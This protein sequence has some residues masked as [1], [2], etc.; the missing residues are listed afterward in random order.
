MRVFRFFAW[1]IMPAALLASC[2]GRGDEPAIL[3]LR[4]AG[5][6]GAAQLFLLQGDGP[7]RQLTGLSDSDADPAAP[8]VIDYAPSPDGERIVYAVQ[9]GDD[10][11]LR[12]VNLDGGQDALLLACPGV[13]CD[14]PVWAPDGQRLLFERWGRA[15]TPGPP[16]LTWLDPATGATAPLIEGDDTP[17]SGARFSPGGEWLSYV[18][19][20]D[21]GLVLYRPSDGAQ[22]LLPSRSGA[23]AVWSPDGAAVVYSDVTPVIPDAA[24]DGDAA[25]D[26]PLPETS[27]VY[28]YRALLAEEGSRE[29]LS[30]AAAISDS[31]AAFAPDGQWIAFTRAPAETDA[32][33]QLW[34]MR[35]D[36]TEARA[37][38]GDP[39][40]S[41]GPPAWSPDGRTLLYQRVDTTDPAARP[42]V[43]RLDVATGAATPVVE[44]GYLPAW[45]P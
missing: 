17:A 13:V 3:F 45:L 8:A 29:R 27:A 2:G 20:A 24:Q 6:S 26:E 33:R 37:L 9:S 36:G 10:T 22:R 31:A 42:A 7:P 34:L 14:G 12:V 19:P 44:D 15:G 30:P 4:P 41:H 18:S 5:D 28:L 16:R 35:P 25:G 1:F 40:I 21:A 23:P 11:A 32:A 39:A 43:W 38:T